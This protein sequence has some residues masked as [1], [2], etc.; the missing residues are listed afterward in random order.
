MNPLPAIRNFYNKADRTGRIAMLFAAIVIIPVCC[1]ASLA[2][3]L[4]SSKGAASP[5]PTQ[6][7]QRIAEVTDFDQ[8]SDSVAEIAAT[9]E[10]VPPAT[11]VPTDTPLPTETPIPPT[12]TP[13]P[14]TSTPIPP[15]STPVPP[16]NTPIPPTATPISPTNTPVPP[17][18]TPM[19]PTEPP[20]PAPT[21]PPAPASGGLRIVGLN[22]RTEYVD[23]LN[24]SGADI[25]LNGWMLRSEKGP[26]DCYLGGVIG[27]GQT[28]RIW[29]MTRDA[30]KGGFNCGFGS[31]IWNNS[32]YD[33]AVLFNPQ[34]QEVS[35][36]HQ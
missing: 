22:K 1:Y 28:L 7:A 34:G 23:I 27:A 11:S 16:T 36:F 29:A 14:P 31:D 6:M 21:Q 2:M 25:N 10:P 35:R 12:A 33:P 20:P 5:T 8:G 26:Q 24:E 18:N 19:P 9:D 13:I 4:I 32:E 15:T 3:L 17:T 30:D